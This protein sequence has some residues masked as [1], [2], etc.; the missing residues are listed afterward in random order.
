MAMLAVGSRC[1]EV[2]AVIIL[3]GTELCQLTRPWKNT[4]LCAVLGSGLTLDS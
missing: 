1:R 4:P 3:L 2:P